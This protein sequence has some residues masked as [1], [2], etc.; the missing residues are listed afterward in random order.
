M[1]ELTCYDGNGDTIHA[2]TQWDLNQIIYID[3]VGFA[4]AP[5]AYF[6]DNCGKHSYVV[7]TEL[8]GNSVKI[9][10]PNLLLQRY[11]PIIIGLCI[12]D[13]SD[14]ISRTKYF[15]KIPVRKT[16]M[17]DDY[18]YTENTEEIT[19]SNMQLLLNALD[20]KVE[21]MKIIVDYELSES[22]ENPVQ[23]RIVTAAINDKENKR[24]EVHIS[25][26]GD[27]SYSADK[28]YDEIRENELKNN[29]VWFILE[30]TGAL[31]KAYL[32]G[33]KEN[34][35][36]LVAYAVGILGT[37]KLEITDQNEIYATTM[38]KPMNISIEDD[39]NGNVSIINTY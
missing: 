9:V 33:Y 22:S 15:I 18:L 35:T 25:S 31:G 39:N 7:K 23:N 21:E 20:K 11:E 34:R 38:N 24:Y 28:S 19:L 37:V 8:V 2:L 12:Y 13:S 17:P 36:E 30:R 14:N 26:N 1:F 10:I 27:G 32:F 5:I 6:N 16:E 4:A 3:N 29:N